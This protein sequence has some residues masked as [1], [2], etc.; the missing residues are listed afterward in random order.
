M[1]K[2]VLKRH[3]TKRFAPANVPLR[4]KFAGEHGVMH[5]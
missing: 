5:H 3:I 4:S 2:E 1:C